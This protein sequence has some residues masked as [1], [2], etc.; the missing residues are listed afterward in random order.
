MGKRGPAPKG[1]F[2]GQSA[3]LSTRIRPETRAA[4]EA[5]AKESGRS[6]SQEIE[7]RLRSTFLEDEKIVDVFGSKKNYAIMR[8]AASLAES[9]MNARDR[10]AD[11]TADPYLY[12]QVTKSIALV[13]ELLR[14]PGSGPISTEEALD[15]GGANQWKWRAAELVNQ[16]KNAD[17]QLPLSEKSKDKRVA[18]RLRSDLGPEI[19]DRARVPWKTIA[20]HPDPEAH[21]RKVEKQRRER[22]EAQK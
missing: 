14:P 6:L 19:V 4:L 12:D 13:F 7:F 22:K 15:V 18:T 5:A 21:M 17:P 11:W 3:V 16:I 1:E 10:A 9:M 20:T 2:T 8:M